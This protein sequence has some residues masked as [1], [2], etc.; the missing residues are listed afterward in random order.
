MKKTVPL[1]IGILLAC[2]S[3]FGQGLRLSNWCANGSY[4]ST[5]HAGDTI[6][7]G[8]SV[9]NLS[10]FAHQN[11]TISI[12]TLNPNIE[13]L[14]SIETFDYISPGNQY[15]LNNSF[16][17]IV[18][19]STPNQQVICFTIQVHSDQ[20]SY[21]EVISYA[22]SACNL[23]VISYDLLDDSQ[24]YLISSSENASI[25]FNIKNQEFRL[26]NNVDL[27]LRINTP[28][29]SIA[30]GN[31]HRDTIYSQELFVFPVEIQTSSSFADGATFDAF[32]DIF[33]NGQLQNTL[34]ASILGTSNDITFADG[35]IPSTLTNPLSSPG[36]QIDNSTAYSGMYSLRSGSIS[37][38]DTSSVQLEFNNDIDGKI[39]FAVKTS[40]ENNYDWLYFYLDGVIIAQ[41]SGLYGW[42]IYEHTLT[43]GRHTAKWSYVKDYS[44]SNNSDCVWIDDIRIPD[45]TLS[46]ATFSITTAPIE[47]TLDRRDN[48]SE[49]VT[50]SFSNTSSKY[51]LF[52]NS[53]VSEE[54]N[55]IGWAK[56]TPTNGSVNGLQQK[57]FTL[58]LTAEDQLSGDYHAAIEIRIPQLDTTV[59]IPLT[60]HI[61]SLDNIEE[62]AAPVPMSIFPNPTNGCFTISCETEAIQN[63]SIY[64]ICGRLISHERVNGFLAYVNLSG[65]P[66]GTYILKIETVQ[67]ISTQKIILQ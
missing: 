31:L 67:G 22:V 41:W 63:V 21:S 66:S 49:D 15:Q 62:Y 53:I 47:R 3:L 40:T 43:A 42:D 10:A 46:E 9:D 28:G 27:S 33:I 48:V 60:L 29:I 59:R 23:T 37:H 54:G 56:I 16:R 14:D 12:S 5:I 8:F 2:A 18:S 11:C 57:E 19:P 32:I 55:L 20:E 45:G 38:N 6:L 65:R 13:F 35:T 1:T 26:V 7:L 24:D 64:D 44:V 4:G 25:H 17:I 58:H 30:N 52:A 50:L 61:L 51:I 36:W 34:I 39:S